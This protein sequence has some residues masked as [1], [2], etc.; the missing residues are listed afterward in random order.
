MARLKALHEAYEQAL[1]DST[2]SAWWI[3]HWDSHTRVL[4]SAEGPFKN[5]Q[6]EHAFRLRGRGY[7]PRLLTVSPPDGWTP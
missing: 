7:G 1:E 2:M 3:Q 6:R 5:C 4:F